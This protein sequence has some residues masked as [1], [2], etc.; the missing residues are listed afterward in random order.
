MVHNPDSLSAALVRQKWILLGCIGLSLMLPLVLSS[1]LPGQYRATARVMVASSHYTLPGLGTE[2]EIVRS[3]QLAE[4]VITKLHLTAD[5]EF[6]QLD[7]KNQGGFLSLSVNVP[8]AVSA[9][10]LA[11]FRKHLDVQ[12]IASS[13]VLV[14]SFASYDAVKAASIANEIAAAYVERANQQKTVS[15]QE[16]EASAANGERLA[17]MLLER[18]ELAVRY[19][20]KHPRMIELETELAKLR[21]A[22]TATDTSSKTKPI[23]AKVIAEAAVPDKMERNAPVWLYGVAPFLGLMVGL[24][25]AGLN[26]QL[27]RGLKS[28]RDLEALSGM[29][30][31]GP[32]PLGKEAKAGLV[33]QKPAGTTAEAI[34]S[35]R[36]GLKL[37]GDKEGRVIKVMTVTSGDETDNRTMLSLWLGR[38]AARSGEKVLIIDANL[39]QPHLHTLLEHSNTPSLVDYLTGQNY[40]EQVIWKQDVSGAHM[41]FG[42][43]V[44]NTALDL[45]GSEKMK[46]LCGY[47]RPSY[48]LVVIISPPCL[49]SA[50]AAVLAN[51]SD[52]T[53][54]VVSAK[55]TDRS[56]VAKGL[57]LFEGFGYNALSLVMTDA[58][59]P[60]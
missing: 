50:D 17:R 54:Y 57:K 35:V 29:S 26:E 13:Y 38:L 24:L 14:I 37:T 2:A 51:E 3:G 1:F 18:K 47:L 53:L 41:I 12:S 31:A 9:E 5:P 40:L 25:L 20:P 16:I 23:E 59:L 4:A 42:S 11:R 6:S 39:R 21:N 60:A 52:Q 44:P 55:T 28:A 30:V 15:A 32:V 22:E 10:M 49:A 48:D 58:K 43:A 27:I 56:D 46:K 34:R 8:Q 33:L 45:I 36:A 7:V 19:G